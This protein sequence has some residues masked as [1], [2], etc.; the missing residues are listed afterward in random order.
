MTVAEMNKPDLVIT[1][2]WMPVGVGLSLAYRLKQ[3]LPG[4]P[5]IFLTASRQAGLKDM[6]RQVGA[7]ALLEKPYEPEILLAAINHAL[8]PVVPVA[9]TNGF[10]FKRP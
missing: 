4:L 3:S 7:V 6:A 5:V 1:D 2:I 9:G 8:E 10:L